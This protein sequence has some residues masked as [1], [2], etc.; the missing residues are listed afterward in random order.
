MIKI[1]S[2]YFV[3]VIIEMRNLCWRTECWYT[4][5]SRGADGNYV[6]SFCGIRDDDLSDNEYNNNVW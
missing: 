1:L 3:G 6:S 5:N 4:G 2:Y